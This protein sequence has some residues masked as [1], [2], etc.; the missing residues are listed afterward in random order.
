IYDAEYY[1]RGCVEIPVIGSPQ[2]FEWGVWV[3]VSRD[4]LIYMLD[5][6]T[7]EI[8]VDEPPRFGWLTTWIQGYPEPHDVRCHVV[9]RSGSLRPL[10][11]LE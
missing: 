1:V 8:P 3:S 4:S 6:W 9:L 7:A 10:I 2:H 11:E 5:R